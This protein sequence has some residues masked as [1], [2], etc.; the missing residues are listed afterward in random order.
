MS[1]SAIA[2][3]TDYTIT[4]PTAGATEFVIT[5]NGK[6]ITVTYS[7]NGKTANLVRSRVSRARTRYAVISVARYSYAVGQSSLR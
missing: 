3:V 7:E 5:D 6:S 1:G 2:A 4:Y